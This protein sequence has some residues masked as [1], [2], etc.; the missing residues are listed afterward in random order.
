MKSHSIS[1]KRVLTPK[2]IT[3]PKNFTKTLKTIAQIQMILMLF[4]LNTSNA[5]IQSGFTLEDEINEADLIIKGRLV[6][7]YSRYEKIESNM[8]NGNHEVLQ[9]IPESIF[10]TYIFKVEEVLKGRYVNE[11]IKILM[12]GGCDLELDLCVD[13]SFN[14]YYKIDEQAVLF[15]TKKNNAPNAYKADQGS[16][17]AF[18]IKNNNVLI[19]KSSGDEENDDEENDKDGNSSK[20]IFNKDKEIVLKNNLTLD[21]LKLKI[22]DWRKNNEKK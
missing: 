15:L 18:A 3:N 7:T 12:V 5:G 10:T 1:H 17:S 19:R 2:T 14:Y 16:Y 8:V 21:G 22:S 6:K 11:N 20:L 9:K 4:V 13:Y